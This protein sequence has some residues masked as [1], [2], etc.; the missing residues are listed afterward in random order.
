MLLVG[1]TDQIDHA[2]P[3]KKYCFLS[4][5]AVSQLLGL[6]CHGKRLRQLQRLRERNRERYI[7]IYIYIYYRERERE[8]IF[9]EK[10]SIL[11]PK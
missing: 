3:D 9:F 8:R 1:R 10:Y 11:N 2:T 4:L 6:R 5:M 7:Y